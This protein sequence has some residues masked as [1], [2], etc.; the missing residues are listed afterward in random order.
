MAFPPFARLKTDITLPRQKT[1]QSR[2]AIDVLDQEF[3]FADVVGILSTDQREPGGIISRDQML[4][5][6][7]TRD[8]RR[9]AGPA[10]AGG[11][12]AAG[13]EQTL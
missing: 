13:K 1:R 10:D 12:I 9:Q 4:V 5:G 8:D 2:H 7:E 3:V 6:I 11:D